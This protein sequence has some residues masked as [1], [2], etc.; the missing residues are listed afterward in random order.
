MALHG[1]FIINNEPLAPLV[2]YGIESFPAYSGDE[3]Y[4]N[5]GGCT[6]MVDIGPYQ[7]ASTG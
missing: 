1:K 7:A 2:I 3:I 5:R 4:R 6:A